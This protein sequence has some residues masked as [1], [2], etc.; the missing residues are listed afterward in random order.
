VLSVVAG[1]SV[2]T[3]Y[4]C[5]GWGGIDARRKVLGS[6]GVL[7]R[8]MGPELDRRINDRLAHPARPLI[9]VL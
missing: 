2:I 8:R 3:A 7:G 4:N 9:S 6:R 5:L 1:D